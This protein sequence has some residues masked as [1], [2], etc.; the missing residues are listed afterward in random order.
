MLTI[1]QKYLIWAM[2]LLMGM[3]YFS[4][5]SNLDINY[6]AKSLIA[7]APIQV[8]SVIYITYLRWSRRKNPRKAI[9]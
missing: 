5:M 8:V 6:F 4:V 2:L 3:G 1:K 9:N 7:I